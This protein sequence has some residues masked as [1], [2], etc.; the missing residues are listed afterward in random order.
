MHFLVADESN[1]GQRRLEHR[2]GARELPHGAR[3]DPGEMWHVVNDLH[4][5]VTS[6]RSDGVRRRS[7]AAL[8]RVGSSP[9]ASASTASRR[10]TMSRDQAY[11]FVRL[12]QAIERADMTTRVL[13]VRAADLMT[14]RATTA[15]P[16]TTRCSGWACSARWRP[17]G[18]PAAGG[19]GPITGHP[20]V[21]FLLRD[22]DFP[23]SI[24]HCLAG[25]EAVAAGLPRSRG[26]RHGGPV[27]H[28]HAGDGGQRLARARSTTAS[29]TCRWRSPACTR[30]SGPRTSRRP[31]GG[32]DHRRARRRVRPRRGGSD[33]VVLVT[34]TVRGAVPREPDD[35]RGNREPAVGALPAATPGRPARPGAPASAALAAR[36][37]PRPGIAARARGRRAR[38]PP[39]GRRPVDGGRGRRARSSTTTS[40]GGPSPWRIDIVP[41]VMDAAGWA[42]LA[43][44][45]GRPGP[46]CWP[47]SS[48]TSRGPAG[49]CRRA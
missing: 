4:L 39:A 36:L 34:T 11:E 47:T 3:G 15:R 1:H 33:R 10:A 14:R 43:A 41:L 44:R 21:T 29:T 42:E 49:C 9:S 8:L 5:F 25:V 24:A 12:G 7:R 23:G 20:T 46:S 28:A 48:P 16:R 31:R 17:P 38:P 45:A 26:G 37:G 19:A 32:H 27:G 40:P 6:D 13:G 22:P 2:A 35:S 30:R 18:V